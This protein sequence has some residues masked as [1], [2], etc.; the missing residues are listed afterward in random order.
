MVRWIQIVLITL[1]VLHGFSCDKESLSEKEQ[2]VGSYLLT[3]GNGDKYEMNLVVG[4]ND[5]LFGYYEHKTDSTTAREIIYPEYLTEDSLRLRTR[6][7]GHFLEFERENG[8]FSGQADLF[9][10]T[11]EITF[12]QIG[13]DPGAELKQKAAIEEVEIGLVR[14]QFPTFKDVGSFYIIGKPSMEAYDVS[15][16]YLI[17]KGKNETYPSKRVEFDQQRYRFTGIGLS[18]DEQTLVASGIE[19][20]ESH[21]TGS[22]IFLIQLKETFTVD[23]I[24]RLGEIV[25]TPSYEIFPSFSPEGDILYASGG[26]PAGGEVKGRADLFIAQKNDD[27]Y[28]PGLIGEVFNSDQGDASPFMDYQGRFII[29]Y[30][31]APGGDYINYISEK[32]NSGWL[33]PHQLTGVMNNVSAYGLRLDRQDEYLYFT[34]FFQGPGKLFRVHTD[35]VPELK[36][37]FN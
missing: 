21:T 20:S 29:F 1:F 12:Q 23:R 11:L 19:N 14:P 3:A 33:E 22:D 4:E 37:F 8:V 15:N 2:F 31:K 18:P 34:S 35:E 26:N 16:I 25:N 30:R 10:D 32:S 36:S 9:G 28:T 6:F 7:G 24:E 17:N 13:T 27:N 5:A